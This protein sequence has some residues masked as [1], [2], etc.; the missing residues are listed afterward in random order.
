[1]DAAPPPSSQDLRRAFA[2]A[3]ATALIFSAGCWFAYG[4]TPG[5]DL[6]P[7]WLAARAWALGMPEAIYA[8][9]SGVF[10]MN[11]PAAWPALVAAEGLPGEEIYP[12]IYP[13][14]WAV[15]LAPLT[16]T[17]DF[18][19]FDLIFG[20]LNPVLL[21]MTVWLVWRA[22]PVL[23][24]R[25]HFALGL[26]MLCVTTVGLLPL[27]GN[28]VQVGVAFLL[29]LTMDRSRAQAE[30]AAGTALALAAA[31][32]LY[33]AAFALLFIATRQ[34]RALAAFVVV[35]SGLGLLSLALAGWD[36]HAAL[37]TQL[38]AISHTV[39]QVNLSMNLDALIAAVSGAEGTLAAE[40][41]VVVAKG[42][43]WALLSRIALMSFILGLAILGRRHRA[44]ALHPLFWPAAFLG[45]SLLGPLSWSFHY[46]VPL[47][48]APLIL[49][50][51]PP[52]RAALLLG[53]VAVA[54]SFLVLALP[55]PVPFGAPPL[56]FWGT[57]ALIALFA[58]FASLLVRALFPGRAMRNI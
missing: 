21:V 9:D 27:M 43:T 31:L 35:G 44:I 8:A 22:A 25:Q 38:S 16:E 54:L 1:M 17:T 47:A 11:P 5:V 14:L 4:G 55:L 20:L 18:A 6:L 28:Q 50:C 12:F 19:R 2:L 53:A 49:A 26:V 7:I 15:L 58:V 36:A 13:P 51:W 45:L 34:P 32:K 46:I 29:A 39:M 41:R 30:V 24:F 56:Q 23:P 10:T 40:G 33:P 57:L 52:R 48:A 37:L 3:L 42:E